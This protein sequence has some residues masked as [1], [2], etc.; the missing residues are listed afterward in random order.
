MVLK[1]QGQGAAPGEVLP[2]PGSPAESQDCGVSRG[3]QQGLCSS[4]K[5]THAIRP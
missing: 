3:R 4:Y 2:A 1:I 5:A